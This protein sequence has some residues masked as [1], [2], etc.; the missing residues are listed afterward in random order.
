M[1]KG[2]NVGLSSLSEA[3]GSVTLALSWTDPTGG[4]EA[5]VSVLLLGPGGKVRSDEDF[6]FYNHPASADGCVQL[7]GKS[8]TGSGSADLI[9]LD[10]AT[11][12]A[13]VENVS[14]AASR[15]AGATFG[16][17]DD[18]RLTLSDSSGE[19]LLAFDITDAGSET[20]FVFGEL[21]R[22]GGE[23]KFRAVGQGY[24]SGLTGLATDFGINIDEGEDEE[25]VEEA[26][27][28]DNLQPADS[29][30]RPKVKH[31]LPRYRPLRRRPRLLTGPV[32]APRKQAGYGPRRRA[33]RALCPRPPR[34]TLLI[35]P[36]GRTPA[37]SRSP[38]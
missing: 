18:L 4:G 30:P 26:P 31:P 19:N 8:P 9:L 27:P 15:Y 5:D 22:R 7:L 34:S 29:S 21:Y 12:P 24:E 28:A 20:A 3:S 25:E 33:R 36:P 1:I 38:A 35:I 14:V 13:E 6:F 32:N 37:C 2:A 11:L 23:W 17:L 10:L 16:E